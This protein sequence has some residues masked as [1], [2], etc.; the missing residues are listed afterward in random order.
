MGRESVSR[1]FA[2]STPEHILRPPL[3]GAGSDSHT[4]NPS[5]E[6]LLLK[7]ALPLRHAGE[8]KQI[9]FSELPGLSSYSSNIAPAGEVSSC[10][11]SWVPLSPAKML[12]CGYL[13]KEQ[14][15]GKCYGFRVTPLLLSLPSLQVQREVSPPSTIMNGVASGIR[16]M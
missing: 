6:S 9:Q 16:S 8:T 2:F 11:G 15:S 4:E 1:G 14:A 10:Q 7:E 3:E 13:P 5:S 12:P